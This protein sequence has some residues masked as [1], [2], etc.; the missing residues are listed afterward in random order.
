MG[1][2][3]GQSA[4]CWVLRSE[5]TR[6]ASERTNCSVR[7]ERRGC[8]RTQD[9]LGERNHKLG[10]PACR[11][12]RLVAGTNHQGDRPRHGLGGRKRD[13]LESGNTACA[14]EE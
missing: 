11:S 6:H 13:T 8:L 4:H 3:G 5:H 1:D 10:D 2:D 14:N 9:L 12:G 7:M